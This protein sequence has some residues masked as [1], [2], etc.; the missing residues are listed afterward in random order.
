MSL[1]RNLVCFDEHNGYKIMLYMQKPHIKETLIQAYIYI[2]IYVCV[3]VGRCTYGCMCVCMWWG[4]HICFILSVSIHSQHFLKL[5]T[6]YTVKKPVLY[7]CLFFSIWYIYT[8]FL[9]CTWLLTYIDACAH[10]HTHTHIT[11]Y[12][13]LILYDK[14]F[15]FN[16]VNYIETLGTAMR[17]KMAPTYTTLTLAYLEE[18]L[19]NR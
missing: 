8:F 14:S 19:N 4:K 13:E 17:T 7:S 9:D 6:E 18:N 1:I 11:D 15:Q 3:C 16:S 10:T 12:I 2:Y 5:K